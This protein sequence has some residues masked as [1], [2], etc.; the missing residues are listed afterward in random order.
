[1]DNQQR[2]NDIQAKLNALDGLEDELYEQ[3]LQ[4][5]SSASNNGR[6]PT[7]PAIKVA[8]FDAKSYDTEYFQNVLEKAGGDKIELLLISSSLTA[9]TASLAKACEV[10][11]IFVNDQCDAST[12]QILAD[13]GIKLI[14][15]RCAGFNNVDLEACK[16]HG[17][18]VVRVP[19]YSP[20]AVSEHAVAL[21]LM[22]NRQ[23]H[24]AYMRNRAGQYILDGLVGFDMFGKTV[25]V[26]GTG[27]IG[28]CVIDILV[29]FGCKILAY[30][31]YPNA[32][33]SKMNGVTYTSI[34][35]II[36]KADI[37]TLHIP[38]SD[39]SK[40][41][42]NDDTISNMKRGVMLINTSRGGLVDTSALIRGLKAGIIGSAGLDVYEEE[43]N[44]FFHDIS[45][46]V[47][48][49][50]VFARLTTFNNV[51]ITSHQAF[52]TQEALTNIAETT[53]ENILEYASGKRFDE[54]SH[55]VEQ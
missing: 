46:Q 40:H 39:E 42:I 47:L 18:S 54:L 7:Q 52:L 23:L 20:Y 19:E 55:S 50:E 48:D 6:S 29:G 38:L 13:R 49:D 3:L 45:N 35:E 17:I 15:L 36:T 11:C 44:I 33:L 2:L 24:K 22:L 53:I 34:E 9:Q 30:D 5:L 43:A 10:A 25:A 14:A 12:I 28:A 31:K 8:M 32:R 4:D 51:V 1:M 37:I 27:K 16:H 41:L 26:I 21:M